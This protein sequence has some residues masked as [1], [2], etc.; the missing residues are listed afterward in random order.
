MDMDTNKMERILELVSDR[1]EAD[2][3]LITALVELLIDVI[4]RERHWAPP[5]QASGRQA[6]LLTIREVCERAQISRVTLHRMMRKGAISF[7][8]IGGRVLFDESQLKEFLKRHQLKTK[9]GAS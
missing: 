9:T 8:K 7:Y 5:A 4:C 1:A 2:R 6:P 3:K